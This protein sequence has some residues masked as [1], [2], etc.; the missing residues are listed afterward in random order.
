[1]STPQ[2]LGWLPMRERPDWHLLKAA[3]KA[4]ESFLPWTPGKM[5]LETTRSYV[6]AQFGVLVVE[7]IVNAEE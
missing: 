3:H 5:K 4:F 1:M 7:F 2:I 6:S